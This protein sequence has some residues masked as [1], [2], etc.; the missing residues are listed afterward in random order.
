MVD[1]IILDVKGHSLGNHMD[2]T[3]APNEITYI[4][5]FKV[6]VDLR[7]RFSTEFKKRFLHKKDALLHI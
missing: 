1:V 7:T 4:M 6:Q 3:A 2:Y 5:L